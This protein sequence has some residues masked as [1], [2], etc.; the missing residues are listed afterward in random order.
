MPKQFI[1]L[2]GEES[3]FQRTMR[4]VSDGA[5]PLLEGRAS[6]LPS[7]KLHSQYWTRVATRMAEMNSRY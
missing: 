1:A 3:T 6:P 2:L 7:V 5:V 4:L